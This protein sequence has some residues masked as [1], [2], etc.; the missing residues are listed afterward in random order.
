MLKG[1]VSSLHLLKAGSSFQVHPLD[2][3]IISLFYNCG[4]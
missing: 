2:S 3:L 1:Y 4:M